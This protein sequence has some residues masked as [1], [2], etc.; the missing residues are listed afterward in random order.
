M[1]IVGQ[2]LW[3]PKKPS[4]P[5]AQPRIKK[6]KL[7]KNTSNKLT[8][9]FWFGRKYFG[10]IAAICQ[11]P[12]RLVAFPALQKQCVGLRS[13]NDPDTKGWNLGLDEVKEKKKIVILQNWNSLDAHYSL[14][15][16]ST[17]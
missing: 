6:I 9:I 12:F 15:D 5:E 8:L 13:G 1:N 2:F 11:W 10:K 17:C 4:V 3:T 14:W 16:K 7:K